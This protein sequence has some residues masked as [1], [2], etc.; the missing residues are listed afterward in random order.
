[1]DNKEFLQILRNIYST[2]T[3]EDWVH[4]KEYVNLEINRLER[5]LKKSEKKN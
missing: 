4:A 1:M 5:E 2:L 3:Y